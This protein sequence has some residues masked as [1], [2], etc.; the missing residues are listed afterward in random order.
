MKKIIW[1]GI[2]FL[3]I[4]GCTSSRITSTWKAENVETRKYNKVLV[5]GL[6]RES[7][8]TIQENMENH[9]VGDLKDLGYDAVSSLR[10]YGPKAFDKMDEAAALGKLKNS[11]IDAVITIVLLNK[12][13]ERRT[14]N[15]KNRKGTKYTF[16]NKAHDF[17]QQI[18]YDIGEKTMNVT[19]SGNTKN[20]FREIPFDFVKQ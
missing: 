13:K 12:E 20:G 2:A 8:R 11:G 10:E 15:E 3:L 16:E 5:L 19:I 4:T 9:L 7:D 1:S 17:P 14:R 6:I 18:I